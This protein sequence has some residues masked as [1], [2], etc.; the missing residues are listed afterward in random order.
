MRS[1][2]GAIAVAACIA[3]AVPA[4]AELRQITIGTNPSGTIAHVLG[5]GVAKLLQ[6]KLGIRSTVEPHGGTSSYV[7]LLAQGELT[8]G[9]FIGVEL[10]L[11]VK[12]Q[13]PYTE[14]V[15]GVAPIARLMNLEYAFVARADSGLKTVAD[16]KGKTVVVGIKSNIVLEKVNELMLATAGL[17]PSDVTA[18][19]AGG[20]GQGLAAVT[21][22][23][24]EAAPIGLGI[25]A[26]RQ[27][28]ASTPG[29]M[30]VLA[31]GDK[32]TNEF[33]ESQLS[34]ARVVTSEPSPR[35]VGV[36][37]P[38][39]V[40]GLELFVNAGPTV[41]D[42]DAY[43]IAKTIYEN[44]ATLQEEIPALRR[45]SRDDLGLQP[46]PVPYQPGAER[47][48]REIGLHKN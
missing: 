26:L 7:P 21:E 39:P 48:Y 41:S 19:D 29:G 5:S 34:G 17:S 37:A 31:L 11:A 4:Q 12:G 35:N 9:I 45:F 36:D 24:A 27:A 18:T 8:L 16:L 23:R 15:K 44:W 10:G 1:L 2:F 20:L 30:R 22:G 14:P 32:A 6:E 3:G 13:A 38:I 40:I 33:A 42:E 28:D 47:F 46:T 43:R 25:P